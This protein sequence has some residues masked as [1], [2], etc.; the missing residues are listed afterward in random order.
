MKTQKMQIVITFE[1]VIQLLR[2]PNSKLTDEAPWMSRQQSLD[3]NKQQ[4]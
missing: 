4:R 3:H 1:D 2:L